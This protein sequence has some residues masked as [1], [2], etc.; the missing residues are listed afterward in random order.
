LKLLVR[1]EVTSGQFQALEAGAARDSEHTL[2]KPLP[3]LPLGS[4]Y[5][6]ELPSVV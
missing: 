3:P 4:L 2:A 1:F 6:P 5:W